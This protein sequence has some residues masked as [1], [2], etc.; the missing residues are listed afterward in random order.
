[1]KPMRL[2][3]VL[4]AV[5]VLAAC[6]G[7][8]PAAPTDVAASRGALRPSQPAEG[9]T[10]VGVALAVN[11]QGGE[12][13]TLIAAVTAAGLVDALS[14]TG[15]RTVFAPTDAA[16]AKLGLT[17]DNVATALPRATLLDILGYHV[18][19]GRRTAADVTTSTLIRM[20]N[21]KFAA[22]EVNATG[23]YIDGAKIVATDIAAS[24][25]IIH[26]VDSVLIP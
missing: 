25:G 5:L 24:N 2:L 22:I 4:P 1:M 20:S 8:S 14:A 7:E 23:A 13:S 16:F 11:R 3:A 15:Q 21:G 9:T 12:F 19:P 17:K 18:A 26:V 10:I 6:G